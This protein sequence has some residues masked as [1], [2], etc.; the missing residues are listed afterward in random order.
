MGG[1]YRGW[2]ISI[3]QKGTPE[4]DSKLNPA[5]KTA[6]RPGWLPVPTRTLCVGSQHFYVQTA[7]LTLLIKPRGHEGR[8][9]SDETPPY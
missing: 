9:E 8:K 3:C 6:D 1:E 4:G 7:A 5:K 2:L